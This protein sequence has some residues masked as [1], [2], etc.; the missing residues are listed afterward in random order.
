MKMKKVLA[1]TLTICATNFICGLLI[2]PA[3]ANTIVYQCVF[4]EPK[5]YIFAEK[6]LTYTYDTI[7]NKVTTSNDKITYINAYQMKD[8]LVL[9]AGEDNSK[10]INRVSLTTIDN[11]TGE[12]IRS[13]HYI[14]SKTP[15]VG[16]PLT[17]KCSIK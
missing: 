6:D 2:L 14:Y 10:G 3:E 12:S 4:P 9:I 15:K 11:K 13:V 8:A 7:T 17:G 16:E 1:S 5:E